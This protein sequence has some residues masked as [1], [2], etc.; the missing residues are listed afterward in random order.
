MLVSASGDALYF[1]HNEARGCVAEVH[2][3]SGCCCAAT[4]DKYSRALTAVGWTE[5]ILSGSCSATDARVVTAAST[6]RA[7]VQDGL[8]LSMRACRKCVR[9][10]MVSNAKT[11]LREVSSSPVHS[12][13]AAGVE[14]SG[15]LHV[16]GSPRGGIDGEP[17]ARMYAGD[18]LKL[19]VYIRL[20]HDTACLVSRHD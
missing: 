20:L 7:V 16:S 5:N 4:S 13:G 10:S 14:L 11:L 19:R 8:V 12:T 18:A 15:I 2:V 3:W 6:L 9:A 1:A 17:H